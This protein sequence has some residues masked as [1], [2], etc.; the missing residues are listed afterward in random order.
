MYIQSCCWIITNTEMQTIVFHD[1]TSTQWFSRKLDWLMA[2]T[3]FISNTVVINLCLLICFNKCLSWQYAKEQSKK[4]MFTWCICLPDTSAVRI[5][6]LIRRTWRLK[7][8]STRKMSINGIYLK[9]TLDWKDSIDN[10]NGK[11]CQN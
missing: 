10:A 1:T 7:Y 5:Q 6:I 2:E 11:C 9:Q 3:H 4:D 8:P